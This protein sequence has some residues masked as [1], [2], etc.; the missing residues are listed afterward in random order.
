MRSLGV[1]AA[2]ASSKRLPLKNI[3]LLL[4]HP[5][6][7]WS[8]RA[9]L[10]SSLTRVILSTEDDRIAEIG[11]RYG[12]DMSYR[13]PTALAADYA[14]SEDIV[15]HA[16]EW[17][18]RND[19]ATYD[20]VAL[21]QP[22]TPFVEPSTIDACIAEV[23]ENR[24]AACIAAR[25][26]NEP[27]AWLFRRDQ[28]GFVHPWI[29]GQVR[30]DREHSQLLEEL[31]F[32]TGAVYVSRAETLRQ[33]RTVMGRPLRLVVMRQERAVDIDDELDFLVAE[34]VGRHFAFTITPATV[35]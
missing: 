20:V 26:G 15:E 3:K 13:R 27:P 21:I 35:R 22:T 7:A 14:G 2:R 32:P 9:A 1:I 23:V 30:G 5:L 18:E 10:A 33:Q 17:A 24:S 11:T 34:A 28:D 19:G 12:A 16:L 25:R 8:L 6:V 29:T 31:F 4:G